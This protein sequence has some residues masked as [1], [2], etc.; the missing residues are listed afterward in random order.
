MVHTPVMDV[1]NDMVVLLQGQAGYVREIQ[2][3]L[4]RA[5][6][7]SRTGPLPSTA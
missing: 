2:Q 1:G 5:A 3:V 7:R 4:E 6:I